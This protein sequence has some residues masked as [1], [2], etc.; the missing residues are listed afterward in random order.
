LI[1]GKEDVSFTT[2]AVATFRIQ[3]AAR[4]KIQRLGYCQ[5]KK[6]WIPVPGEMDNIFSLLRVSDI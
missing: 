4:R 6:T 2:M 5:R 3:I 1:T